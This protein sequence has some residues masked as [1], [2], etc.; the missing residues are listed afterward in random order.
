MPEVQPPKS[1]ERDW[2]A[3]LSQVMTE[4]VPPRPEVPLGV[5]E[6]VKYIEHERREA[7]AKIN[8]AYDEK[9]A[10]AMGLPEIPRV[11]ARLYLIPKLAKLRKERVDDKREELAQDNPTAPDPD[12]I[13]KVAEIYEGFAVLLDDVLS[14]VKITY[15]EADEL[16]DLIKR[17]ALFLPDGKLVIGKQALEEARV[18]IRNLNDKT[19]SL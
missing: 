9:V 3:V 17:S 10:E 1:T 13:G 15:D 16:I 6:E 11:S 7:I 8:A 18:L 2:D 4:A 14:E 19:K 12:D 5:R